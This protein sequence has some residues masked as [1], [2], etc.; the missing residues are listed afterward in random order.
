[1]PPRNMPVAVAQLN[2]GRIGPDDSSSTTKGRVKGAKGLIEI[3]GE[4]NTDNG[5]SPVVAPKGRGKAAEKKR[6][7]IEQPTIGVVA[8]NVVGTSPLLVHNWNK[9]ALIQMLSK[10]FKAPTMPKEQRQPE[11]ETAESRYVFLDAKGREHE[12]FPAGAFKAAIVGACRMVDGIPMTLAKR[13][14]FIR[15]DGV[16][17]PLAF[18]VGQQ[19]LMF[20]GK[21]VIE[22]HGDWTMDTGMIRVDNGSPDIR[23]RARYDDWRAK[24]VIE[25]NM[26][27][28]SADQ[29]ATLVQLAGTHEGIGEMRPSSPFNAT[30]EYGRWRVEG[31]STLD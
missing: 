3:P 15:P 21:P 11:E 13:L 25:F 17:K 2:N 16:S 29:V 14:V 12:A 31:L 18:T 19:E 7:S 6:I 24:L 22:I 20:S 10:Q 28:L 23:F 30:G 4:I 1:M 8:I 26:N 27:V 5:P 9:K